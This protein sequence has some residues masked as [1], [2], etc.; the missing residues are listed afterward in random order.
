[1]SGGE[2]N[3][4]LVIDDDEMVCTIVRKV[5]EA[6]M[7]S[8]DV[9]LSARD[10]LARLPETRY[11]AILCD[12]W[13]PGMTGKDFY[14]QVKKQFPEYQSRIIFLTGDIASEAT[15]DFIEQKRLPY[16]LKP[17][18]IPELRRK[19]Q[20]V[21]GEPTVAPQEKKGAEGRRH[22]RIAMKASVRV[23]KKKWATGGPEIT[24]VGN[25]SKEGVYFLTDRQYRIG[26]EVLVSFPYTGANDV[27][28]E[29]YVVR[30]DERADGRRGVAIALGQAAAGVREALAGS[31][32]ERQRDRILALADM[33]TEAPRPAVTEQV[34]DS[35]DL[36][37][38]L[39][40]ERQETRRLT[41]EL[42]NLKAVHERAAAERDRLAAEEAG[43]NVE[44][45]ELNS[46]RAAMAHVIEDLKRQIEK[47]ETQ[48]AAAEAERLAAEKKLEAERE[49]VRQQ[50][51]AESIQRLEAA[52]A[53]GDPGASAGGPQVQEL[54]GE[55]ARLRERLA[56]MQARMQGLHAQGV[57]PLTI[58]AA[59]CDMLA[60]DQ[61]LD[62]KTQKMAIEIV[63][64]ASLLR[65]AFQKLLKKT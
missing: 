30:V 26:T 7:F 2:P 37:L 27:D 35:A 29:G 25:A 44:W 5:L 42:S 62:E 3:K 9:S 11:N 4:V 39:A 54:E 10:A 59:Y 22:H 56:E 28:Q 48:L 36:K 34:A 46:A 45:R 13:M 20:E 1:M 53:S 17:V 49:Q 38:Q 64:Q 21:I 41:Q 52:A 24:A 51:A 50:R 60:M 12:M 58:L 63:Q 43:R 18:N 8:V 57:G 16:V 40:R 6:E 15:W 19:L 55:V 47:L 61:S 31:P 14:H 65:S 33:T 23:R 32:E